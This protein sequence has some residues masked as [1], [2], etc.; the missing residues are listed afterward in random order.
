MWLVESP[1]ARVEEGVRVGQGML[2]DGMG[3]ERVEVWW[4][5]GCRPVQRSNSS[6]AYKEERGGREAW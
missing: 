1:S 2:G 5:R 3:R 4:G 6:T